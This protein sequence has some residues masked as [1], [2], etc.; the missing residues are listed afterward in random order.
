MKNCTKC[1]HAKWNKTDAGRLHPSG[2]GQCTK[3]VK[4]PALPA[5]M[6]WTSS[7]SVSYG[8]ISRRKDL[9]DHCVYYSDVVK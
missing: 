2:E 8:F 3:E 5:A 9:K 6:Y 4:I 7:P 1:I